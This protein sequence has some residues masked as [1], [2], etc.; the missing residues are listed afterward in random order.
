MAI[1]ANRQG[2]PLGKLVASLPK[3][4]YVRRV[5]QRDIRAVV[6]WFGSESN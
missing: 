6:I 2:G 1:I 3:K 4:G 5:N